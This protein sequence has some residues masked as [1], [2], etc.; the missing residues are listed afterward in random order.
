M[1][2]MIRLEERCNRA[3]SEKSFRWVKRERGMIFDKAFQQRFRYGMFLNF[4]ECCIGRSEQ[5][6][7]AVPPRRVEDIDEADIIFDQVVQKLVLS[8]CGEEF[9]DGV[10]GMLEV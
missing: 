3:L 2:L 9:V 10:V 5:C 7:L 6:N 1:E 8:R 4:L